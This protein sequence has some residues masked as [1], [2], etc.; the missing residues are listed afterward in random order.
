MYGWI[1]RTLPGNAFAK[2]FGCLVLL[3]GALALLFFVVFP[4]AEPRLPFNKVNVDTEGPAHP[5][6]T[7]SPNRSVIPGD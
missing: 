3:S 2:L 1:W 4:Y 6:P 5:S 7:P